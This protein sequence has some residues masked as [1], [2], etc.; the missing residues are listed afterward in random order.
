MVKWLYRCAGNNKSS[1]GLAGRYPYFSIEY[2]LEKQ[3]YPIVIFYNR[4]F[5]DAFIQGWIF[6]YL[7]KKRGKHGSKD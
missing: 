6:D 5:A 1:W 2:D 3:W 4:W 7:K